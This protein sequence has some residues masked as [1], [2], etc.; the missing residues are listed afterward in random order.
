MY[1]AGISLKVV[2]IAIGLFLVFAR[3]AGSQELRLLPG[4]VLPILENVQV[5]ANVTLDEKSG[6]YTYDYKVSNPQSNTGEIW[7]IDVDITK[8]EGGIDVSSEGITNGPRYTKHSS[9]LVLSRIGIPL[10]P[11]GLFSPSKWS[12]GF[13]MDGTAGWGSFDA[14][15]RIHPGKSLSGFAITSHGLP[16]IRAI[17]IEPKFKQTPVDEA[18]HEDLE[19]LSSIKKAIVVTQKTLGPTA[20]PANFVAL[21]FL[22]YLIDLKHQ[23][24]ELGW[25]TNKGVENSLDAKLDQV[26]AKLQ[27]GD[28]KTASNTLNAFLNE[29]SAQGCES[30]DNCPKGKH[31]SPEAW[32]LLYFNGKYL[33]GRL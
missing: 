15:F 6:I 27:A 31:L 24:F 5:K 28:T 32:G 21:D 23:A 19:R 22:T 9:A 30:H 16:G 25:I 14:P 2:T 13:S 12:S 10:I 11:V 1:N 8:P 26:K 7:S 17:M 29:V 20:P 18:T 33:L 3:D 4:E